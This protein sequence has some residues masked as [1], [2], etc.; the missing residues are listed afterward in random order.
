MF[1]FFKKS[2]SDKNVRGCRGTEKVR[3]R[4]EASGEY[5]GR[6]ETETTEKELR[7]KSRKKREEKTGARDEAL[8]NAES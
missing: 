4:F 1:F 2:L 8:R 6:E 5:A 3:G 7:N